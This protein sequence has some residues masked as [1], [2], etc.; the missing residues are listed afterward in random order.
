V[1]KARAQPP[2]ARREARADVLRRSSHSGLG[3]LSRSS[4]MLMNESGYV[5]WDVDM[6]FEEPEAEPCL[7]SRSSP[8]P[9]PHHACRPPSS[10]H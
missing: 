9:R 2:L 3:L 8:H 10:E 6:V 1:C 7:P 4:A 5:E